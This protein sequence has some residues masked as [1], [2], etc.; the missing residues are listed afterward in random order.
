MATKKWDQKEKTGIASMEARITFY[1][2]ECMEFPEEGEF[3]DNLT[4]E[5][6]YQK[7]LEIPSGRMNAG[8]G[9]G[10]RLDDGSVFDSNYTLMERGKVERMLIA[11]VPHYAGNPLVQKAMDDMEK[12]LT[13]EKD[14]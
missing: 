13:G 12:L 14:V 8:K 10:F 3:Y 6:A 1:A 7:Y 11:L 9:V 2:A 4:L 5:E